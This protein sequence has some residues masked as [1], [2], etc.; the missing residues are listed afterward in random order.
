[1]AII[2]IDGLLKIFISIET[3]KMP[4]RIEVFFVSINCFYV[5]LVDIWVFTCITY[6]FLNFLRTSIMWHSGTFKT[7]IWPIYQIYLNDRS[8]YLYAF[9]SPYRLL[10]IVLISAKM[11]ICLALI[12]NVQIFHWCLNEGL[13]VYLDC[14][15]QYSM[16]RK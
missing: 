15:N 11:F 14:F 13:C 12:N 10:S 16:W 5:F 2:L 4:N 8:A 3:K 6:L 7:E 9:L 1:M